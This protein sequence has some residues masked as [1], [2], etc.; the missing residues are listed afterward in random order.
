MAPRDRTGRP[1]RAPWL[2]AGACT[3]AVF[4]STAQFFSLFF[5]S[6]SAPLVALGSA[7]IDF[8]PPWLKDAAIAL[9]GTRDKLVL[10]ICLGLGLGSGLGLGV[11]PFKLDSVAFPLPD[12]GMGGG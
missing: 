2:A 1:A 8:T 12:L 4:F 10:L 11:K 7:F 5:A 6:A 9:F 3:A